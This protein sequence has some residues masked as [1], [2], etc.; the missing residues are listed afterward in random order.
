MSRSAQHRGPNAKGVA[1]EEHACDEASH[2]VAEDHVGNA[3]HT[4]IALD[5]QAIEDGLAQG[6]DVGYEHILPRLKRHVAQIF[7]AG[8]G[9]A[10]SYM[11]VGAHDETL[12]AQKRGEPRIPLDVL[13]HAM[14][15]LDEAARSLSARGDL[16]WLPN[17]RADG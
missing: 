12:L 13:G 3:T 4:H 1:G 10:M 8:N 14:N 5:R 9:L 2:G 7:G 11:V 6:L 15:E 16:V 17:E